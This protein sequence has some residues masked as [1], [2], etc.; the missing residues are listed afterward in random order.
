MR[1]VRAAAIAALFVFHASPLLVAAQ[2]AAL[3]AQQRQIANEVTNGRTGQSDDRSYVVS[4]EWAHRLFFPHIEGLGGAMIS[5]G[6]DQGYTMAAVARAELLYAVDYDP[7][8]AATHRMYGVLVPEAETPAALLDRFRPEAEPDVVRQIEARLGA[9]AGP[10]VDVYRH[11]RARLQIYLRRLSRYAAG[12]TWLNDPALYAWIRALH[13]GGRVV[14][15]TC[16]V[17]G[18]PT[19]IEIGDAT[20]RLGLPVRTVYLSNLEMFVAN[21]PPL[22]ANMRAL[23]TDERSV[24]LR[25]AYSPH[26][27]S[28]PRDHWHYVVEPFPDYLARLATGRYLYANTIVEDLIRTR[29]GGDGF[30]LLDASVPMR[31]PR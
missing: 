4:N 23:N 8:I 13:Q 7:V 10:V 2:P 16:D 6:A 3:N 27:R 22:V 9:E 19:L 18:P 5:V 28:A 11:Y 25:T 26:L 31:A 29:R 30:S 15:R 21:R 17:T 12:R 14:A 20:R 24:L 1:I